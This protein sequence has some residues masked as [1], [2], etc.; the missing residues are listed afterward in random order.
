MP[1]AQSAERPES[2][3]DQNFKNLP[4]RNLAFT[5]PMLKPVNTQRISSFDTVGSKA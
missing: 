2:A 3:N 1:A 4:V 5:R